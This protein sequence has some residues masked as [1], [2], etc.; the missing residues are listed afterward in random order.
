MGHQRSARI[1]QVLW[2][3]PFVVDASTWRRI[4]ASA[5]R[6]H[7]TLPAPAVMVDTGHIVGLYAHE[8]AARSRTGAGEGSVPSEKLPNG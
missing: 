8:A 1:S 4:E 7:P 2:F 6:R 5:Q 3:V